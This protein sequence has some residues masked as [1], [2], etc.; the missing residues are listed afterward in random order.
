MARLETELC[1]ALVLNFLQCL[2]GNLHLFLFL[3]VQGNFDYFLDAA[4]AQ[5]HGGAHVDVFAAVFA[6]KVSA[7]G[8]NGVGV[9]DNDAADFCEDGSD[10]VVGR[11]FGVDNVVGL[12]FTR[13]GLISALD[14]LAEEGKIKRSVDFLDNSKY[15]IIE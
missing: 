6:F 7:H 2:V 8:N 9:F 12:S 13:E 14:Q 5:D 3:F 10:A 11:A 15:E 4:S 1:H